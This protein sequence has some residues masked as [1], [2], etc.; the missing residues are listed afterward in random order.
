MAMT[1]HDDYAASP[2]DFVAQQVRDYEASD[3][4]ENNTMG[5]API[6]IL[7]TTGRHSGKLRKTPLMRVEHDGRYVVVASLGGAP[8]HPVWYLNLVANPR[9]SLQDGATK[10]EANARPATAEERAEWW[11]HMTAAWPAYDQ[12]QA[13]TDREIPVVILDPID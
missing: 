3:G 9:V 7:T 11:P 12:Y 4:T 13:S 2:V 8:K 10:F 5:D 6:V 1:S